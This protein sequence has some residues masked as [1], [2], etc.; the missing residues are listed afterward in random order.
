MSDTRKGF[1]TPEQEEK[2]DR[3]IKLN[4]V[5]ESVDGIAIKLADNQGL[6]RLKGQITEKW[7]DALPVIYE[8][9]DAI[10][11]AIPEE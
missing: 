3:V 1:L 7:P 10:I 2:L 8:I 11:E 9:I 6:E 5:A 4:G